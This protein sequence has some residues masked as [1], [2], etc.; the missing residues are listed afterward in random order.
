MSSGEMGSAPGV[1]GAQATPV[2]SA[3]NTSAVVV[4]FVVC[5]VSE[6]ESK[7]VLVASVSAVAK[8]NSNVSVG[9]ALATGVWLG[10]P[11]LNSVWP[12]PVRKTVYGGSLVMPVCA[13]ARPAATQNVMISKRAR[14]YRQG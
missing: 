9:M 11:R 2:R 3:V 14:Q 5:S 12:L 8:P 10:N 7:K 1:G 6:K 4:R 13:R